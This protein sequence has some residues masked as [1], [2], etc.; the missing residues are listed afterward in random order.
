MEVWNSRIGQ[1][2]TI[3]VKKF[4]QRK[5]K[6]VKWLNKIKI[7]KHP[8]Q[9][10][11]QTWGISLNQSTSVFQKYHLTKNVLTKPNV[12]TKTHLTKVDTN[13]IY[14]T[15]KQ[16][17]NFSNHHCLPLFMELPQLPEKLQTD[18]AFYSFE[19]HQFNYSSTWAEFLSSH[20]FKINHLFSSV[21]TSFL[22]STN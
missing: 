11:C 16:V 8:S 9:K 4:F 12:H 17:I 15:K 5:T 1:S 22:H 7:Q 2:K 6:S 10:L 20:S 14:H 13:T 21:F 19:L 18:V 3:K